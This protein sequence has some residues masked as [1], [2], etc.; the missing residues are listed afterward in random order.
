MSTKPQFTLILEKKHGPFCEFIPC[1]IFL[2]AIYVIGM[3][4]Q[5]LAWIPTDKRHSISAIL[6]VYLF[7][8]FKC[9]NG[10]PLSVI[11]RLIRGARVRAGV[12]PARCMVTPR[13]ALC[14][15]FK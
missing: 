12:L 4:V 14:R 1:I 15:Y 11:T 7:Y 5:V 6:V 9:D 10:C 3:Y 13:G 8:C 2:S